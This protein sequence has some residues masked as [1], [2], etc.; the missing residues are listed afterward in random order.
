M[1]LDID[2]IDGNGEY[3]MIEDV[4]FKGDVTIENDSFDYAGTHCTGGVGGTMY[5]PDYYIMEN[6]PEW[7]HDLYTYSENWLIA[8][9]LMAN[10]S[11]VE[12]LFIKEF[13]KQLEP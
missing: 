11:W 10:Y 7:N 8:I 12:D 1:K 2:Y 6:Y 5:Y 4:E 9:W 13:E 3:Q